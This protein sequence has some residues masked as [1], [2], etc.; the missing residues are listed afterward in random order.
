M[1]SESF[2][3]LCISVVSADFQSFFQQVLSRS[4]GND[5]AFVGLNSDILEC[6]LQSSKNLFEIRLI[7]PEKGIATRRCSLFIIYKRNLRTE[8]SI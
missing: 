6:V 2:L 3:V 5:V 8:V 7:N 4:E 1:K